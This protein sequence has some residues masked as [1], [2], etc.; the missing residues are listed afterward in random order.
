VGGTTPPGI[1]GYPDPLTQ[2]WEPAEF[3][4]HRLK[5]QVNAM[6]GCYAI[7]RLT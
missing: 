1:R 6:P 2:F 5:R 4:H 3:W 7:G